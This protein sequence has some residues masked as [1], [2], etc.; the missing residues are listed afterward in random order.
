MVDDPASWPDEF[1]TEAAALQGV[2]GRAEDADSI[3]VTRN[4]VLTA[5]NKPEDF[6]LAVVRFAEDGGHEVRYFTRA[7]GRLGLAGSTVTMRRPRLT[8]RSMSSIGTAPSSTSSP[9]TKAPT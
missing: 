1:P 7:W 9:S 6:I 3:T 4:D 8:T 5:Q 2:M